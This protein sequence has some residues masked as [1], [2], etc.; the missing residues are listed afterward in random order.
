MTPRMA[1]AALTLFGFVILISGFF[2]DND[3]QKYAEFVVA[4]VW[5]T[6]SMIIEAMI[7]ID[8]QR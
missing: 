7:R 8:S 4:A 2:A 3:T 1:A 6:G 5:L